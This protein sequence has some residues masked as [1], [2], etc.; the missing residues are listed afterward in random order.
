MN[1]SNIPMTIAGVGSGMPTRWTYSEYG[2]FLS[3]YGIQNRISVTFNLASSDDIEQKLI[4]IPNNTP[5]P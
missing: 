1:F 2:R 4:V 5:N 3:V